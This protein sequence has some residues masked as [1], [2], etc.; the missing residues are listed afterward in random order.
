MVTEV[1]GSGRSERSE[2][3]GSIM[4]LNTDLWKQM[5]GGTFRVINREHIGTLHC[6][7]PE[8]AQ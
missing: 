6:I 5:G 8:I 7:K 3:V 4:G 2:S 1:K